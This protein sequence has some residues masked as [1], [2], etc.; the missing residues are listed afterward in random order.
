M[1]GSILELM[2]H[3]NN[4]WNNLKQKVFPLGTLEQ[5]IKDPSKY[6]HTKEILQA[7]LKKQERAEMLKKKMKKKISTKLLDEYDKT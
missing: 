1:K 5:I 7:E 6:N 4:F 3:Y 2:P